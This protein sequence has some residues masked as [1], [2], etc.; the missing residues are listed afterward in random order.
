M[1]MLKSIMLGIAMVAVCGVA[2]AKS[3]KSDEPLTENYVISTYVAAITQGNLKDFNRIL[4]NDVTFSSTEKT[5]VKALDKDDVIANVKANE[6][7]K[8][9]CIVATS[10]VKETGDGTVYQIDMKY[11]DH[12]RTDMVT[13]V[14]GA[15]GWKVTDVNSTFK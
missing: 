1:K 13:I 14:E 11:A 6:G 3:I 9:E 10:K 4:D 2:N 5:E 8:Q 15:N 12:T 7:V